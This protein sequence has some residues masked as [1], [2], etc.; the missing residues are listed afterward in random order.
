MNTLSAEYEK[1]E[2][3]EYANKRVNNHGEKKKKE[4]KQVTNK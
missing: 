1:V 4:N 2:E 3:E